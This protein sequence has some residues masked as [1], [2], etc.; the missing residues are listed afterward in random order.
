MIRLDTGKLSSLLNTLTPY[1][2][3]DTFFMQTDGDVLLPSTG[4]SAESSFRHSLKYEVLQRGIESDSF[5]YEWEGNTYAVSFGILSRIGTEWIYVS[6]SPVS[7]ILKPMVFISKLILF[8]SGASLLLVGF[9]SWLTSLKIYTPIDRLIHLLG[10][11]RLFTKSAADYHDEFNFIERQWL[12]LTRESLALQNKLEQ[13]LPHVK[14]GFLLQLVQ[15]FL[16]LHSEEE[17]L[18]RMRSFGWD[19]EGRQFLVLYVQLTGF[20]NLEGRFSPGDEGLV[21]FA[22]AN[23]ISELAENRF[24]Q[25]NMINFHDLSV[26]LFILHPA[27]RPYQAELRALSNELIQ[28]ISHLLKLRVSVTIGKPSTSIVQLHPHYEEV[29]EALVYRKFVSENQIIDLESLEEGETNELRYPF[30]LEREIIQMLR[31]G[32]QQEAQGFIAAFLDALLERGAKEIDVQQCMLQLL[33]SILHTIRQAGM[34]PNRVFKS[35]NLYEQLAQIREPQQMLNWFDIR[36]V[37]PFVQELE[38]RPGVQVTKATQSAVVYLQNRYMEDI[39][40]D[41]CAE[42]VGMSPVSLSKSFKQVIGKNFIDYLTELRMDKAKELLRET[43]Q[44]INDIAV[45]VGYQHSYFNRLFKKLESTTP[46]E[47]RERSRRAGRG[48]L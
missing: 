11:D 22:A 19:V 8:V 7:A 47:Y 12:H 33:G 41:S 46:S 28:A 32:H 26:G 30:A 6:A 3:G 20:E 24:E 10:A 27:D 40:L 38:V 13:Q 48:A 37:Q 23:I 29:K 15:G 36:V 44:K 39:S 34:D 43:D 4:T 31:T 35:K 9:L 2:V 1:N 21:T 14:E 17:L 45:N 5:L 18:E 25:A 42:H 16:Y